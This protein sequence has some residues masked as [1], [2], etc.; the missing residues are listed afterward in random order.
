V[1]FEHCSPTLSYFQTSFFFQTDTQTD[2]SIHLCF[3][4]DHDATQR[5]FRHVPATGNTQRNLPSHNVRKQWAAFSAVTTVEPDGSRTYTHVREEDDMMF[6]G[7]KPHLCLNGYPRL[8]SY[9]NGTNVEI[10]PHKTCFFQA[11]SAKQRWTSWALG[12]CASLGTCHLA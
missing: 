10:A 1:T 9:L 7:N 3:P 2:T 8:A 6:R 12:L 4:T 11:Y 5:R